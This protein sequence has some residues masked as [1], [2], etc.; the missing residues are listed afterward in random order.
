MWRSRAHGIIMLSGVGHKALSARLTYQAEHEK[1]GGLRATTKGRRNKRE[2]E[3]LRATM[4]GQ[5]NT[6]IEQYHKQY[7]CTGV[8]LHYYMQSPHRY[9]IHHTGTNLYVHRIPAYTHTNTN[10]TFYNTD[11]NPS[12]HQYKYSQQC[13]NYKMSKFNYH[14][15]KRGNPQM[16][17]EYSPKILRIRRKIPKIRKH[18]ARTCTGIE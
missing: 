18:S 15:S 1:F 12:K 16:R 13:G 5:P 14:S 10:T 8:D 11:T 17:R 3:R 2:L 9:K 4:K 7:I 6:I